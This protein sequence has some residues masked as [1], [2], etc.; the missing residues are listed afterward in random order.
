MA[1]QPFS[2]AVVVGSAT[3]ILTQNTS[4][5]VVEFDGFESVP[6]SSLT[7]DSY[8]IPGAVYQGSKYQPR[9]MTLT[10]Y[11]TSKSYY[12]SNIDSL[13]QFFKTGQ[14]AFLI[15]G[16]QINNL[17]YA[18]TAV[19]ESLTLPR[20]NSPSKGWLAMQIGLVAYNPFWR[21]AG[22]ASTVT[23][24][25]NT[26]F[27]INNTGNVEMPVSISIASGTAISNPVITLNSTDTLSLTGS[28]SAEIEINTEDRT[29]IYNNA[30]G[31]QYWTHGSKWLKLPPGTNTITFSA[32]ATS[33]RSTTITY[34][35]MF[36]GVVH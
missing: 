12:S 8:N 16:D 26:S 36:T 27:S 15:Y 30:N 4:Q 31:I 1:T 29:I 34:R 3:K 18:I 2:L 6:A 28:F 5:M 21:A 19:I 9:P 13:I 33:T 32:D 23:H 10:I 7:L 11:F 22:L 17:K 14:E 24:A 25:F 35:P 20:F